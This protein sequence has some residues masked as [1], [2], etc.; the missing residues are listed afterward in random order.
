MG[1]RIGCALLVVQLVAGVFLLLLA[2]QGE[3]AGWEVA[4]AVAVPLAALVAGAFGLSELW[5]GR[6]AR[7]A[8]LFLVACIVQLVIPLVSLAGS[9]FEGDGLSADAIA[10]SAVYYGLPALPFAVALLFCWRAQKH[11]VAREPIPE[12]HRTRGAQ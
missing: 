5:Q 12:A 7:A 3:A 2:S 6:P 10:A 4:L 11:S 1:G 8:M 9:L